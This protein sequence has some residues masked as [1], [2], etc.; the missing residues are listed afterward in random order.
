MK[1]SNKFLPEYIQKVLFILG[2]DS[3]KLPL[4]IFLFLG[5]ALIDLLGLSLIIPFISVVIDPSLIME[6]DIYIN[7]MALGLPN[8]ANTL[9]I[10]ISI[11]LLSIFIIKSITGVLVNRRILNF[12][13]TQGYL[14][15]KKLIEYYLNIKY[16]KYI[17]KNSSEY[18]YSIENL[19]NQYSQ[20]ILQSILRII[21][22][23][24]IVFMIVCFFAFQD[25][26]SL[27]VL[28]LV[29]FLAVGIYEILFRRKTVAYGIQTNVAQ[30]SL[31]RGVHEGIEGL[32]E[33][34]ILGAT[35][36]FQ[37]LVSN[38]AQTYADFAS[39]YHLIGQIPKYFIETILLIFM[40]SVILI[41]IYI[42]NPTSKII[43]VLGMFGFGALRI[44]PSLNQILASLSHLRFGKDA[45]D[46]LYEDLNEQSELNLD[47][48]LKDDDDLTNKE[49]ESLELQNISFT[50]PGSDKKILDSISLSINK[51]DFIGLIGPSGS[52]K[53]TLV[54]V[55]MGLF[56]I[57]SGKIN[58]NKESIYK[59]MDF[60]RN[61][62]AYLPQNVFLIDDSIKNNIA[63]GV[64]L[65]KVDDS[66]ISSSIQSAKLD[67][68]ISTLPDGINTQ[69]GEKGVRLSGGQRQRIALAR[70]FYFSRDFLILD[71]STSSLDEK[72]EKE[73]VKEINNLKGDRTLLVIAHR[74][75]TLENC[76]KIFELN[77]GKLVNEYTYET[78]INKTGNNDD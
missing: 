74:I 47:Y 76:D 22:E 63:M 41:N 70:A 5:I 30:E 33:I 54:D 21:S 9:I 3:K 20:N 25:I 38:S 31:I 11:A 45:L 56:S 7:N 15:R 52:G 37:N 13:F 71:E 72:I 40:V 73:I 46:R 61:R 53:T 75:S 28:A 34:R 26:F 48:I 1:L 8:E 55:I 44:A 19:A 18:V 24:I 64:S 65:D 27:I 60:W 14:L 17:L 36:F 67:D 51:G 16:E 78:L 32:K 43:P 50:F 42:G 6:S 66:R 77:D 62:V 23:V 39:R 10:L 59:N 35:N 29:I 57:E 4:M 2:K 69:I 68:L 12:C 49:F 58:V